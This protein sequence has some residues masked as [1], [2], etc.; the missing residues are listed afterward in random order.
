MELGMGA[1]SVMAINDYWDTAIYSVHNY[2]DSFKQKMILEAIMEH[3]VEVK[4]TTTLNEYYLL[5]GI[6]DALGKKVV[7]KEKEFEDYP[8]KEQIAQF[9][10]D[11]PDVDFV[12]VSWNYSLWERFL[13]F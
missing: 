10:V 6:K 5:R 9:L 13:P 11:N 1:C 4:K 8:T 3:E 7:V 2:S 12:S